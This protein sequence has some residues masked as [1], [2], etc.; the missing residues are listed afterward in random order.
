MRLFRPYLL[1]AV[2]LLGALAGVSAVPS[3]AAHGALRYPYAPAH[4]WAVFGEYSPSSSHI[5]LGDAREREFVALGVAYTHNMYRGR[6]WDMSYL[7]EARPLMVESDPVYEGLTIKFEIP[8]DP[9]I[10]YYYPSP[11][12]VPVLDIGVRE[13]EY[14]VLYYGVPAKEVMIRHYGRR[15]TYVGGMSPLGLKVNFFPHS[16]LQPILMANGGFAASPRDIP[17]FD[18][19][20]G[21]FT[22]SFGAGFDLF[23]RFGH[24]IRLEYRIQHF[25]NA[26]VGN[27]PGIDSQMIYVGYAWGR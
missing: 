27:D 15:W 14:A 8:G 16:R 17:M 2:I 6:H 7:F 1:R 23:R 22:F 3:W 19:S 4:T 10:Q 20:A 18:T 11:D 12:K 13:T 21:N 24:P 25:S 26:H 9:L 5:I